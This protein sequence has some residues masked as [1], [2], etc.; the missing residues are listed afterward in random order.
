MKIVKGDTVYL[1]SGKD[2]AGISRLPKDARGKSMAE[3]IAAANEH[4]GIRGKVLRVIPSKGK[5]VVE[6][7]NKVTKHQRPKATGGA[8]LVQQGGRIEFE[9]PIPVSRVL[10][11][12]P[13]C[14]KPT[15]V[16]MRLKEESRRTLTGSKMTT[17]RERICKKC[18]AAI[19]TPVE[20]RS[21][22]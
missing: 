10:L 7:V 20:A 18:G 22:S 2:V 14:Q 5:I 16:G 12:C 9:A 19:P 1:R 15:R 4:P 11:V 21:G 8:G 6:G 3:Q 13:D 17:V